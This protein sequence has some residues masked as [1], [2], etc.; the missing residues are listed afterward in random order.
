MWRQSEGEEIMATFNV[1][2]SDG[3]ERTEVASDCHTIEQFINSRFGT[4]VDLDKVKV[5]M[6]DVETKPTPTNKPPKPKLPKAAYVV[7]EEE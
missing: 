4:S 6:K 1:I 3:T 7:E 2:Y 5:S